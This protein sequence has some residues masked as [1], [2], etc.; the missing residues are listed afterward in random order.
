VNHHDR[1]T[2]TGPLLHVGVEREVSGIRDVPLD[3]GNDVIAVGVADVERWTRLRNRR[4]RAER[5][6][7]QERNEAKRQPASAP[8]VS[9][10][11]YG[12]CTASA[13]AATTSFT[14]RLQ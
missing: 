12:C 5:E 8:A 14:L 13:S 10:G 9:E 3:A 4:T 2:R 7:E 6:C 1:W 11:V